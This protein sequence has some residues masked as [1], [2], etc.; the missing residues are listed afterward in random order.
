[1]VE[2]SRRFFLFGAAATVAT[3]ALPAALE[4][5]PFTPIVR[6]PALTPFLKRHIYG[7]VIVTAPHKG[8]DV[9]VFVDVMRANGAKILHF[10]VSSRHRLR[11]RA[12]DPL[13]AIVVLPSLPVIVSLES[14]ARCR[15]VDLYCDDWVDDG[16]PIFR[17]ESHTFSDGKLASPA[18]VIPWDAKWSGSSRPSASS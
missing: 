8:P 11:W 4:A 10:G 15:S 18:E 12:T 17:L 7:L 1:M 14:A 16:P 5:T 2:L 9:P 3:A 13:A 6:V